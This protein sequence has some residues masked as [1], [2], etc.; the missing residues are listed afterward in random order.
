MSKEFISSIDEILKDLK[1]GK[2]VIM[3]DDEDRENEG[4][5]IVPAEK[6]D[7]HAINF[8]AT[9]GRGL[10]CLSLTEERV[11]ELEIP[12]MAQNNQGRDTTA[13]TVSIEAK[14]GVTTGI[15]AQD[16]ATTIH[17]AINSN[18]TKDDIMS[19]GHIFPLVA[20]DGGVLV[21]AGHTEASV[22]LARL[23]GFKPAGVICE[24]M[25]D[26]GTMARVPDLINFS[27][28]HNIKI[29]RIVDL[30]SYRRKKDNFINKSYD[31]KITIKRGY[32]FDIK[33]FE[34]VFDSTE[35]IVL[36]KGKLNDNAPVL[37]RVHV[38]DYFDNLFGNYGSNDESLHKSIELI[39]SEGR[40]VL[41]LI[42]DSG[43][44][45]INNLI[46][47]RDKKTY[48]QKNN[49]NDND[50]LRI[51]GMGAQILSEL[52]VKK[53]I[54]LTNT[55]WKFIGLD[56]YDISIVETRLLSKVWK[57]KKIISF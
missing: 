27:K 6:V 19:P 41:I 20:R 31:S 7:D 16:R 56:A 26:D 25:N 18:K 39:N 22:D 44:S 14:E 15:S 50:E 9:H 35:Q 55:E 38:T 24:I 30:I 37:V 57:R 1:E 40:G 48:K 28:K 3:V 47:S 8:M 32:D 49:G 53:M 42:R 43:Q 45:I 12:L 10:I 36:S 17:T 4:D 34:S 54:L 52:G 11:K 33:I 29:G 13:F 46:T 2:M 51:Y 5:L 23:A 21:R